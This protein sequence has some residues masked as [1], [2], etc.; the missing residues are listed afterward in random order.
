MVTSFFLFREKRNDFALISRFFGTLD[1]L[2]DSRAC[3]IDELRGA[4]VEKENA[5]ENYF[6]T[7]VWNTE[8]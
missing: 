7:F 6:L 4:F 3:V 5:R 1:L 8:Q 2:R